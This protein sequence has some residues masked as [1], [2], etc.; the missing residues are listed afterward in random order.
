MVPKVSY[1]YTGEENIVSTLIFLQ[2]FRYFCVFRALHQTN[3]GITP[4]TNNEPFLAP[5]A[6]VS[7]CILPQSFCPSDGVYIEETAPGRNALYTELA[8]Y[9]CGCLCGKTKVRCITR[10]LLVISHSNPKGTNLSQEG[11][12]RRSMSFSVSLLST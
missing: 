1:L 6:E 4:W 8:Q 2:V 5:C 10:A 12:G 9:E 7:P 3:D 11:C